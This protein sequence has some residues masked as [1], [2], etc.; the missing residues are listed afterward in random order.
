VCLG[1]CEGG[2]TDVGRLGPLLGGH[3]GDKE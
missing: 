2:G 3:G 1:G